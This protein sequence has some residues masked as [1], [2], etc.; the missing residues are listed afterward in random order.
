MTALRVVVLPADETACGFYRMRLPAGA[1]GQARP[2]WKVE[3]YR[4]GDV[5]LGVGADGRLWSVRGIP[6]PTTVDV[7]VMQRV[8]SRAQLDL[9]RWFQKQGAAVVL[10]ADDAMWCIDP[11]NVAW[12]AW[13]GK[14]NHWK[15]LDAAMGLADLVTVTTDLLARRYGAHG[16]VEVLPNCVPAEALTQMESLR[17]ALDQTTTVGWAGFTGTHPGDLMVM[18]NS[19]RDVQQRTGCL[20]RVVGDAEGAS[21]DW[22]LTAEKVNPV[23]IGMPYYTALTTLDIGVV[24]LRDHRFNRGK[25]YLKALEFATCGVAVVASDSPA[26]RQLAKT[27]PIQLA[28]SPKEWEYLLV[29]MIT[30][31]RDY[32]EE[33]QAA[34]KQAVLAHHTYEGNAERWAD[35]WARAARRRGRMAG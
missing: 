1:V 4:P 6:D 12:E 28:T 20:V 18:G 7:V 26:N 5:Q 9:M 32:L 3:L 24:P 14:P 17:P 25:S 35:V 16:R 31:S 30:A 22:G 15:F 13:N 10:D 27:V 2:D 21:L 33:R 8:G 29:G 23:P 19:M 34:A 11:E